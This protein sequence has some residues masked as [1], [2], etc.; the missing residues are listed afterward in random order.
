MH[1]SELK[2][3]LGDIVSK[4]LVVGMSG[5]LTGNYS[6]F[7]PRIYL[8][9]GPTYIFTVP[10]P[11][12]AFYSLLSHHSQIPCEARWAV[13]ATLPPPELSHRVRQA[14]AL[15][16]E[17]ASKKVAT[18]EATSAT[19]HSYAL[20]LYKNSGHGRKDFDQV[21]QESA[22][23]LLSEESELI[24]TLAGLAV[25]KT[26]DEDPA[27]H[28]QFWSSI[29]LQSAT[30]T[31]KLGQELFK[32]EVLKQA[33]RFGYIDIVLGC[34]AK[35]PPFSSEEWL[36]LLNTKLSGAYTVL[37]LALRDI[38]KE[39]GEALFSCMPRFESAQIL[40]LLNHSD[41]DAEQLLRKNA[42]LG[43]CLSVF[44]EWL[45]QQGLS[46]LQIEQWLFSRVDQPNKAVKAALKSQ[47]T[48]SLIVLMERLLKQDKETAYSIL[49]CAFNKPFL[50]SA[51]T[52]SNLETY[53]ASIK[54]LG[55]SHTQTRHLTGLGTNLLS[56]PAWSRH[57][58]F[59]GATRDNESKMQELVRSIWKEAVVSFAADKEL[60]ATLLRTSAWRGYSIEDLLSDLIDIGS[61][62]EE[63]LKHLA[64]QSFQALTQQS[65]KNLLLR[66]KEIN[67]SRQEVE[68]LLSMTSGENYKQILD[69]IFLVPFQTQGSAFRPYSATKS[70][71]QADH[72]SAKMS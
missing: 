46:Q 10:A 56:T 43:S 48:A 72:Q 6:V 32:A 20:E 12:P 17:E 15:L 53:W 68:K 29:A 27:S 41:K 69:Q 66:L 9:P 24:V 37:N 11:P 31:K 67:V 5:H 13:P 39:Q 23:K 40:S 61:S 2:V 60:V 30:L 71:T 7:G 57:P 65:L 35:C 34:L 59:R 22:Q 4:N 55:L 33:I 63:V 14:A 28:L 51:S 47:D 50:A 58:H 38:S 26:Y 64:T 1:Q 25:E 16:Q 18:A 3:K 45:S 42:C 19:S 44:L 8:K 36:A 54:M 52:F 49:G 21:M 62:R 70:R